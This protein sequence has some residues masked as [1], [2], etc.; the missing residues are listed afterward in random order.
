MSDTGQRG[1]MD[2][3]G[4]QTAPV[5]DPA[6]AGNIHVFGICF[7]I[8]TIFIFYV[9]VTTWPVLVPVPGGSAN[10][11]K[12]FRFF[13]FGPYNWAPDLRMLLTVI[14]EPRSTNISPSCM[15]RLR[16]SHR[17]PKRGVLR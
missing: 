3:P 9:L 4:S 10:T 1:G 2:G 14:G 15:P 7:L 8:F 13:G 11:F 5:T 16:R 6:S 12:P 17:R